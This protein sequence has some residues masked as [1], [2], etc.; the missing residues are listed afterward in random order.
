VKE[1]R[2]YIYVIES[3]FDGNSNIVRE[4]VQQDA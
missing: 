1:N 3:H 2:E 4:I